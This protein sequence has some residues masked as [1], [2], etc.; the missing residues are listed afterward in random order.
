MS[1]QQFLVEL[2]QYLTF[3][4]PEDKEKILA[5][6]AKMFED[7]GEEGTPALLA[8]LGTPMKLTIELKRR[9][10]A[11]EDIVPKDEDEETDE[12][13][14]AETAEEKPVEAAV[15]DEAQTEVSESAEETQTE[16]VEEAAPE[17]DETVI[18]EEES[19]Q[20]ALPEE[21]PVETVEEA[22]P[23]PEPPAAE[24]A[25]QEPIEDAAETAE[26]PPLDMTAVEITY[27]GDEAPKGVHAAPLTGSK[28][29]FAAIGSVL[30]SLVVCAFF[31]A[32]GAVGM[33]L[34]ITMGDL[35]IT[36]FGLFYRLADALL[37]IGLGL[38]TGAVGIV[39]VWF[40]VW[41]G[42]TLTEKLT[43]WMHE[44][45]KEEEQV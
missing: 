43:R 14:Q 40:C 33:L 38:V 42:V 1:K 30:L 21:A 31:V 7:A 6:Y 28:K 22:P 19:A 16:A 23:E 29:V 9:L 13:T 8:E 4:S 17:S 3:V 24:E 41:A 27:D 15:E 32:L 26:L 45:E 39:I 37:A 36:G 5:Y 10:E 35:L 44:G 18:P 12:E 25:P 11:G 34:I 2:S 20:E